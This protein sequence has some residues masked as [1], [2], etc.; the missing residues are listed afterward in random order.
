[1]LL[2]P[3]VL[4]FALASGILA[5]SSSSY[6]L[7]RDVVS[8]GSGIK[9]SP[10]YLLGDTVGQSA[11]GISQSTSYRLEAGFWSGMTPGVSVEPQAG[12][13]NGNGT[14][15]AID[16]TKV[17]RIIVGLDTETL[18]ADANQDGNINALD[19]TKVERLIAGL[20]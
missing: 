20:D 1:M 19:I 10:S 15:D 7:P 9:V 4:C 2:V 3:I 17:E 5:M 13:A 6:G 12:D 14:I 16:I 11:I 18:W 8:S